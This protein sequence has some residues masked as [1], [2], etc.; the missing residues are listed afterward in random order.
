[1]SRILLSEA[2]LLRAKVN[3]YVYR[4]YYE[5][6]SKIDSYKYVAKTVKDQNFVLRRYEMCV[7]ICYLSVLA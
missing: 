5:E 1:M 6:D 2:V 3:G 4:A 7:E